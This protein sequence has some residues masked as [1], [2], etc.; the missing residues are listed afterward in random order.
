[1][2]WEALIEPGTGGTMPSEDPTTTSTLPGSVPDES[3]VQPVVDFLGGS[4][5]DQAE[6]G[7]AEELFVADCM[8]DRGWSYQPV[9]ARGPSILPEQPGTYLAALEYRRLH[10]WGRILFPPTVPDMTAASDRARQA[11]DRNG[12]YEAGL[13]SGERDRFRRDLDG[14]GSGEAAEVD[15]ESCRGLATSR[16]R[17]DQ[18]AR[19]PAVFAITGSAFVAIFEHPDFLAQLPAYEACML[20]HGFDFPSPAEA[21]NS[22]LIVEGTVGEEG[23]AEAKALEVAVATADWICQRHTTLPVQIRME[24][25]IVQQVIDRFPEYAVFVP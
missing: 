17:L 7:Y 11:S 21:L 15:P 16:F 23:L 14:G 22:I 1:M 6:V 4:F 25:E 19:D 10:G 5:D 13:S 24:H 12:V 9:D 8:A 2:T 18:P 3:S 20:E